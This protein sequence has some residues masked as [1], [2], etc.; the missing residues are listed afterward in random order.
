MQLYTILITLVLVWLIF[1]K[2]SNIALIYN[3]RMCITLLI[4]KTLAA[5]YDKA[6]NVSHNHWYTAHPSNPFAKY[7][8]AV[9]KYRKP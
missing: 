4:P 5:V 7:N 9:L 6:L 2:Y 3:S 1:K 8:V